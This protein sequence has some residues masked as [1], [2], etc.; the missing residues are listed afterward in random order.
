MSLVVIEKKVD[1]GALDP[2]SYF[3]G[4]FNASSRR[5]DALFRNPKSNGELGQDL[6]SRIGLLLYIAKCAAEQGNPNGERLLRVAAELKALEFLR[7]SIDKIN[8]IDTGSPVNIR[9]LDPFQ[10]SVNEYYRSH[11]DQMF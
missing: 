9:V 4:A 7:L 1:S 3:A 2:D 5:M 8:G 6:G 10:S 11:L